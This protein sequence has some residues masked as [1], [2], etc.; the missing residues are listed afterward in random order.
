MLLGTKYL[1]TNHNATFA[2]IYMQ[3]RIEEDITQSSRCKQGL[4]QPD[5]KKGR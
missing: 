1:A 2:Y 5:L 3:N 4:T